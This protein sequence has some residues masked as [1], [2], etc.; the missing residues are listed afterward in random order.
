M[1]P[2]TKEP[3]AK[4]HGNMLGNAPRVRL[5]GGPFIDAGT[6]ARLKHWQAR[7]LSLGVAIDR[8]TTLAEAVGFDPV[9][10]RFRQTKIRTTPKS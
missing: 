2:I 6:M 8:L 9:S 7:G 4:P 1:T 5:C 10:K 3:G